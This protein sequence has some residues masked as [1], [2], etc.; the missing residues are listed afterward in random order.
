MGK[1]IFI[2]IRRIMVYFQILFNSLVTGCVLALAA[3]GFSLVFKITR[4]FHLAQ[5]GIYVC[6]VYAYVLSISKLNGMI[7]LGEIGAFVFAVITA[8]IVAW[9]IEKFIYLPIHS[10]NGNDVLSL[11]GSL[12][13]NTVLINLV[14]MSFGNEVKTI[15]STWKIK[16]F[17]PLQGWIITNLQLIQLIVALL[18]FAVLF[19]LLNRSTQLLT[20]KAVADNSDLAEVSGLNVKRIR[21]GAVFVGTFLTVV[22]G[23]LRTYDVGIEPY[24]GIDITLS[25][26]VVAILTG[27]IGVWQTVG[28][29]IILTLLQN[30]TEWFLSAQWREGLTFL[31]LLLVM[32]WRTEGVLSYQL[33][34]DT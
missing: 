30:L 18:I 1:L 16:T 19:W 25:A 13:A 9:L 12:G 6:G 15:D 4:A 26:A 32:L 10:Q 8:F 5:A 21:L 27:R 3:Y 11:V 29:A 34:K 33:R 31:I 17:E 20:F 22:A 7:G 14:A 23:I 2:Y 24:S 28:V